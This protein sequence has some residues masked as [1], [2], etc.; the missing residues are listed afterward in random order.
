MSY[1]PTNWQTGDIVSSEK[2]NKMEE[3]IANAHSEEYIVA[4]TDEWLEEN[5]TQETGYVLDRSLQ[6]ANAAAPADI[7]GDI[8]EDLSDAKNAISQLQPT[9]T[10]SDVGKALIVKTVDT[11]TGKPT[12]YEYGEAGGGQTDIGLSVVNGQI[13]VSYSV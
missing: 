3:G 2:L 4:E 9:A 12:S 8:Q 13:C 1:T 5:I 6:S 10:A 7:V 11:Q